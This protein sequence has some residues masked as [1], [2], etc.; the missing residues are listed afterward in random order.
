MIIV[1]FLFPI[2]FFFN[3]H[4]RTVQAANLVDPTNR[5]VHDTDDDVDEILD[6]KLVNYAAHAA[7][8]SVLA[9]SDHS[10]GYNN[11]LIDDK[12]KYGMSPCVEKKW[13]VI[14]LSEHV[15]KEFSII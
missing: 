2:I 14:G 15:K 12:D 7:G 1:S 8:A 11:L 13:I 10:K 5:V 6:K 9:K 4:S 3:I